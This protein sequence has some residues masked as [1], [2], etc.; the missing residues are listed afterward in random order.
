MP[1]PFSPFWLVSSVFQ[2][3]M[4]GYSESLTDPS[5]RAQL[6]TL[7]FPLAGNYGVPSHD[8]KDEFGLPK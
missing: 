6:L 5:Y 2:T 8:D 4:V 7:T 1:L 3:G